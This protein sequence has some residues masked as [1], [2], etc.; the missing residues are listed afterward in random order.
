MRS[1]EPIHRL[2]TIGRWRAMPLHQWLAIGSRFMAGG[3]LTIALAVGLSVRL[4]PPLAS[5]FPL[6]DGGLFYLMAEELRQAHYVLPDYTSYNSAGIPFTY[7]PFAI[8]AAA[9]ISDITRWSL[10][11]IVRMLPA[12]VSGLTIPAFFLFSR[13]V[14][15]SWTH[16][17]IA[18]FAFACL[19]R[20]S[21]WFVMGGGLTRAPGF[22]FAILTLYQGYLLYTVRQ[23]RYMTTTILF[24]SLTVLTHAEQ[25]W[26]AVYS[27]VLLFLFFGRDRK[28]VINSVFV[29]LGVLALTAPWWGIAISHH[30]V[31]PFVA[32]AQSGGGK[33]STLWPLKSFLFTQEALLPIFGV[34]GLLGMFVCL[35]HREWFLPVWLVTIFLIQPRAAAT[36]AMV[37]TAM[38]VSMAVMRMIL[39]SLS[40]GVYNWATAE[41]DMETR[42]S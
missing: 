34:L 30:G 14:L 21:K 41:P 19:P 33:W 27:M 7:P 12:I 22:L 15:K 5:D 6:N 29:A 24:G 16:A 38:L 10:L 37:P 1:L 26:F 40:H 23:S 11:D 2:S 42:R 20:T 18:A 25:T 17:A 31:G 39:P 13:A 9:I 35:A 8:Y 32:A 4:I 3:I 36:P 28:G